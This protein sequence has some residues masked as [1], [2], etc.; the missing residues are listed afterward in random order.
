[1]VYSEEH[2][3]NFPAGVLLTCLLVVKDAVRR[4]QHDI[5]ELARWEQFG[6]PFFE[7]T[8]GDVKARADCDALVQ[9]PKQIQDNLST[10]MV[11][12]N[13]EFADVASRLHD[14][15]ELNN[16]FAAWA[17]KDLAFAAALSVRDGLQRVRK[18]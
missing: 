8:E 7:I 1:M 12:N 11:V 2:S 14:L 4:R 5:P 6:L 16:H 9:P 15:E 10:A 18:H 3:Q 13:L 17:Y